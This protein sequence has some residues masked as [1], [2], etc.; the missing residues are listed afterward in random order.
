VLSNMLRGT[1]GLRRGKVTGQ[2]EKLHNGELNDLYCSPNTGR[3]IKSGR[4][5]WAGH[6]ARMWER[7]DVY[8]V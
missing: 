7:A 3:V 6:V 2:W 4:M 8:R 1:F 5:R